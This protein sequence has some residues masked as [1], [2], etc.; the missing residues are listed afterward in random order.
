MV[1]DPLGAI[2]TDREAAAG[3]WRPRWCATRARSAS[4]GCQHTTG[5]ALHPPPEATSALRVARSSST[6]RSCAGCPGARGPGGP[7]FITTNPCAPA[8]GRPAL[9]ETRSRA[10]SA[11]C[12]PGSS[13]RRPPS[14]A[15]RWR[16]A[17]AS[18]RLRPATWRY[19]WRPGHRHRLVP[20]RRRR[21]T[22]GCMGG[23]MCAD[24]GTRSPRPRSSSASSTRALPEPV[25][26]EMSLRG[27]RRGWAGRMP[28]ATKMMWQLIRDGSL[29][30]MCRSGARSS[31]AAR[32]CS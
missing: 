25:R 22:A 21:G 28:S 32:C 19:D 15:R 23:A 13:P 24:R 9:A 1:V 8:S 20:A 17:T 10:A 12:R 18:W 2:A 27:A 5:A 31:A 14:F 7:P 30:W 11:L 4:A 6:F 3:R 26:A 29:G 16:R